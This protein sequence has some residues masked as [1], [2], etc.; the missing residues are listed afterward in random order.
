M[1]HQSIINRILVVITRKFNSRNNIE[2]RI[3]ENNE[4][5]EIQD[6]EIRNNIVH[7]EFVEKNFLQAVSLHEFRSVE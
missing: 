3:I 5:V 1:R 6:I 4:V 2:E 7:I